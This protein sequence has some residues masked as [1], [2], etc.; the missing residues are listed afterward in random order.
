MRTL[1]FLA[2]GGSFLYTVS[3]GVALTPAFLSGEQNSTAFI[4][5]LEARL[6]RLSENNLQRLPQEE[7]LKFS[8]QEL[9]QLSAR[10]LA[11]LLGHSKYAVREKA[12][13]AI[14][15][16]DNLAR[17]SEFILPACRT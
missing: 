1:L 6:S 11:L 14:R 13:A 9:T 4:D 12:E 17:F 15:V 8:A 16:S 5:V 3:V 10:N 2:V 7:I